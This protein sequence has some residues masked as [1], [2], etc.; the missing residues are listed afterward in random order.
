M[1]A[2]WHAWK[3]AQ[4]KLDG[5]SERERVHRSICSSKKSRFSKK[6]MGQGKVETL[7]ESPPFEVQERGKIFFFYRPKVNMDS[8]H[9]VDDIQR[10]YLVLRPESGEN[11][12]EEKQSSQSG[13]ESKFN[14]SKQTE[15]KD[16]SAEEESYA[17]AGTDSTDKCNERARPKTDSY[18]VGIGTIG[19]KLNEAKDCRRDEQETESEDEA[20][21]KAQS[22]RRKIDDGSDKQ[23]EDERVA[24]NG[25]EKVDIA[26]QT[27]LRL[28]VIGRKSL[29]DPSKRSR[30]YWG[31]VELVTTDAQDVR[32]VRNKDKGSE[33]EACVQTS[34]RGNLHASSSQRREECAHALDIQV[35][36]PRTG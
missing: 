3:S 12:V 33:R 14:E 28:L 6:V 31:F 17:G 29:P 5:V 13:K 16:D 8:A 26:K 27:L 23:F 15:T 7:R 19:D 25:S 24:G 35:G 20:S 21:S 18:E 34:R 22:K 36:A 4:W 30:P 32:D 9:S 1:E 11:G 2:G 10:M